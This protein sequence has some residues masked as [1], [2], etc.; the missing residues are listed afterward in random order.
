MLQRMKKCPSEQCSAFDPSSPAEISQNFP[1]I[2]LRCAD[3]S[4]LVNPSMIQSIG[5]LRDLMT[6]RFVMVMVA[7]IVCKI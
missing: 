4:S 2:L 6:I 7:E 5:I 1:R 3:E